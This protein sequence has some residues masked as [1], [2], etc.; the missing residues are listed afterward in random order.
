M[1]YLTSINPALDRQVANTYPG[2]A[3]WAG[4]GPDGAT[5]KEC[6]FLGYWVKVYNRAG[7]RVN[8]RKSAGC[9]VFHRLTGKH[10][11]AVPDHAFACRHF[12]SADSG[13]AET[14]S[15]ADKRTSELPIGSRETP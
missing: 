11:P 7:D 9:A 10:G 14:S 3:H 4:T 5:C 8:T 12:E 15:E 6:A 1:P 2:Q 13:V